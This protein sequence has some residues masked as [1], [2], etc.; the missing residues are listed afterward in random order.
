V[1]E[2]SRNIEGHVL[3]LLAERSQ[4]RVADAI[5]VDESTMSRWVAAESGLR[6]AC[7]VIAALGLRLRPADQ[8]DFSETYVT[9]LETLAREQLDRRKAS[10]GGA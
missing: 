6:R 9:A 2:S 10:R 7:E 4:S 5:G 8:P 1:A 3:R